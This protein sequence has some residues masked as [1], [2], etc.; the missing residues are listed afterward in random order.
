MI[1]YLVLSISTYLF[2]TGLSA[3][4]FFHYY[5]EGSPNMYK[6]N[7]QCSAFFSSVA[8]PLMLPVA[9]G[10]WASKIELSFDSLREKKKQRE[11][12]DAKHK[13]E[14]A[15]IKR[16]EDEELNRQLAALETRKS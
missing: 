12:E 10:I 14:L 11:I 6:G 1:V 8:W 16:E 2:M 9:L 3:P 5:Y 15:R 7:A 4:K 13:H